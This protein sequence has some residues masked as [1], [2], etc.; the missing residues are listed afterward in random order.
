MRWVRRRDSHEAIAR[1]DELEQLRRSR[2]EGA[3]REQYLEALLD[4]IQVSITACDPHGRIVRQNAF[5]RSLT[6]PLVGASAVSVAATGHGRFTEPDGLTP[7]SPEKSPLPLA[8]HEGDVAET[9]MMLHTRGSRPTRLLVHARAI[10][11]REGNLLGAVAA[12]HDVTALREREAALVSAN[13]RL[14]E[15]NQLK[16]DLMAT[17]SHEIN[18]PLFAITGYTDLLVQEWD[19]LD[20]QRKRKYVDRLDRAGRT[21]RQLIADLLLMFRVEAGVLAANPSLVRISDVLAEALATFSE[22]L[23]VRAH[24]SDLDG[25]PVTAFV[26]PTHLRQILVS[27]FINATKHGAPPIDV[28]L[29][30]PPAEL[31]RPRHSR[32]VEPESG[33]AYAHAHAGPVRITVRD[34]G[35][36]VPDEFVPRLF[37]RFSRA[38]DKPGSGLGLFIVRQLVEAN[39][40][41]VTYQRA[42]PHGAMFILELPTAAVP[43]ST[44]PARPH[45]G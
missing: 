8:L 43:P 14:A 18:Q 10:T 30:G 21:M 17:L 29:H 38:A 37:D 23:D 12:G 9:E 44:H 16:V 25:D 40:G 22:P 20:E 19:D 41:T 26:D 27:L 33:Q 32:P 36:G 5:S 24:V 2:D 4:A 1:L 3:A 45:W 35:P 7:I 31:P 34:H 42:H 39:E 13:A 6:G 28:H 15:A 11:D